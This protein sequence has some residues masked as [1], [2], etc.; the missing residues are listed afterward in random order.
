MR[1]VEMSRY[2]FI[3]VFALAVVSVCCGSKATSSGNPGSAGATAGTG[4]DAGAAGAYG[5]ASGAAGASCP[6]DAGIPAPACTTD[7]MPPSM[8][9]TLLMHFCCPTAP[10]YATM[11]ACLTT[12][13]ALGTSNPFKQQC[14]SEHLCNATNDTGSER[15]THCGHG[16]GQGP[17]DF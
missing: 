7:V 4:V 9:C 12:Y 14:E 3:P 2:L 15:A 5:G 1:I 8:F 11:D 16:V 10:G 13:T 17:C 6:D